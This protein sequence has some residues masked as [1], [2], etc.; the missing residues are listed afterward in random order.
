L[1]TSWPTSRFRP[2]ATKTSNSDP[3]EVI[4]RIYELWEEGRTDA[5][6]LLMHPELEWRE[7]PES[8]DRTIVRGREKALGAM[9][10]W[11]STWAQYESE[12]QGMTEHGDKVLM[13][14]HQRM[15]GAGSG[16]QV[17]GDLYMLWTVSDGVA[18]RMA[19]FTSRDEALAELGR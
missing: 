18:T 19:M 9:M 13:H 5:V 14:L 15:T 10:M 6:L 11:L 3:A 1:P 8:P 2:R 7:P 4:R 16:L 17:A 12:L